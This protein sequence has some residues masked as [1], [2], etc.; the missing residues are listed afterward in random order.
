M[1]KQQRPTCGVSLSSAYTLSIF[2]SRHKH[3][4]IM[5]RGGTD[6]AEG[7]GRMLAHS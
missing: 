5:Y 3:E 7:M 6:I 1:K 4:R 2:H